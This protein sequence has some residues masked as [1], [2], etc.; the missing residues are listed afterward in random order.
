MPFL[1]NPC[2]ACATIVSLLFLYRGPC[3]NGQI[4]KAVC[5]EYSSSCQGRKL[6]IIC[7]ALKVKYFSLPLKIGSCLK[8]KTVSCRVNL[9]KRLLTATCVS[10]KENVATGVNHSHVSLLTDTHDA[11]QWSW[12]H[13]KWVVWCSIIL[14]LYIGV[15]KKIPQ[16]KNYHTNAAFN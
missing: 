8:Y 16:T 10:P 2:F 13:S 15:P 11:D 9:F 12:H 4:C 7:L 6:Q 5:T 1:C 3:Y 14:R